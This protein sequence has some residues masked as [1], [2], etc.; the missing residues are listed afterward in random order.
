MVNEAI[1]CD[2]GLWENAK[3]DNQLS[4]ARSM[5]EEAREASARFFFFY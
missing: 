1:T 4:L 3:I 2:N 5:H